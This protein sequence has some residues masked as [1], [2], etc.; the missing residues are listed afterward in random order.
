M[1]LGLGFLPQIERLSQALAADLQQLMAAIQASWNVQHKGNGQHSHVVAD[2]V[3]VNGLLYAAQKLRLAPAVTYVAP[4]PNT[5]SRLDDL[6]VPGLA[7]ASVLK[8]RNTASG[9]TLTGIDST[10]REVGDLL[11]VINDDLVIA[12]P[13]DLTV[14]ADDSH[15]LSRNRFIGGVASGSPWTLHGSEAMLL[16]YDEYT[17]VGTSVLYGWRVLSI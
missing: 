12:D 10:G 6:T 17:Y 5:T 11:V 1:R 2:S 8:I 14:A 7:Q 16:M 13:T 9:V 15:S 4:D 3:R